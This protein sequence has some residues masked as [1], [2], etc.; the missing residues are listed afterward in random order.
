MAWIAAGWL[1]AYTGF[2]GALFLSFRQ[3][4]RSERRFLKES[5]GVEVDPIQAA[6]WLGSSRENAPAQQEW[7]AAEVAVRLLI[8]AGDAEVDK[9]GRVT[10][11]PGRPR[12]LADPV[13]AALVAGLRR[14]GSATVLELR[15]DPRFERFRTVLES[16]R[17]PLRERFGRYRVPAATAAVTVA[18]G[19][20]MHAMIAR[21]GVPG[22]PDQDPGWWT[23]VW[24]AVWAALAPLAGLWPPEMSRPW[25]RFTRR[26]RVAVAQALADESAETGF[27]VSRSVFFAPDRSEGRS[28]AGHRGSA[29]SPRSRKGWKDVDDD[30]DGLADTDTDTDTDTG[31]DAD[32][33]GAGGSGDLGGGD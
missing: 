6:W 4:T 1:L 23:T 26:C 12:S 8:T 14:R 30:I 10:L 17:A 19:M 29:R 25:P 16:R 24:M 3:R 33:H 7:Y 11:M 32:T 9:D 2:N 22:L 28:G 5:D 31:T 15:T 18:F 27:R 21:H 13:L 20:S